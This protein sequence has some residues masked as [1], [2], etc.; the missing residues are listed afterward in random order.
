MSPRR[1][2]RSFVAAA[3]LSLALAISGFAEARVL[4]LRT[5]GRGD[6]STFQAGVDE[7]LGEP[8]EWERDTL[9]VHPGT[10]DEDVSLEA[11]RRF[12]A[13]ILCIGGPDQTEVRSLRGFSTPIDGLGHLSIRGL[14][15]RHHVGLGV[16]LPKPFSIPALVIEDCRF[17]GD[18]DIPRAYGGGSS[19]FI[20]CEFLGRLALGAAG[21]H[22]SRCRFTGKT[23]RLALFTDFFLN[24][25]QCVFSGA[26]TAV[27]T[28]TNQTDNVYFEQCRFNDVATGIAVTLDPNAFGPSNYWGVL[29]RNCVFED[30]T[31]SAILVTAV[32]PPQDLV[33]RITMDVSG[34]RFENCGRAI[35]GRQSA[36]LALRMAADTILASHDAG[37]EASIA[38]GSLEGVVIR[39]GGADGARLTLKDGLDFKVEDCHFVGNGGDGLGLIDGRGGSAFEVGLR[40]NSSLANGGAGIRLGPGSASDPTAILITHN[41]VAGNEGGGLLIQKAY[42]GRTE[43]NNAWL[44]QGDAFAGLKGEETNL[45]LDPQ[46]C[47]PSGSDVSVA[48][49][50]PCGPQGPYGQIGARGVGCNRMGVA[51]DALPRSHRWIN[52]QSKAGVGIA[53]LG[54]RLFD[55]RRVDAAS[56][57]ANGMAASPRPNGA[58]AT[59]VEDVN[60]D[61]QPDL[62]LSFESR[63]LPALSNELRLEGRTIDGAAFEGGDQVKFA[64]GKGTRPSP[65]L[66]PGSLALV[67]PSPQRAGEVEVSAIVAEGDAAK[68]EMF[69]VTGRR[70]LS[71]TLL[72]E[73]SAQRVRLQGA[74]D[75]RSGVYLVRMSQRGASVTRRVVLTN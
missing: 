8:S 57:L 13:A 41:L 51:V 30:I 64:P 22:V 28:V 67:V 61:G 75:L 32:G 6:V 38:G 63:T 18:V 53:I 40:R 65:A 14:R 56:V 66:D 36:P 48:S 31:G 71:R 2:P 3:F 21:Y 17:L 69:D 42:D 24:V 74:D 4:V 52:T 16:D 68:L 62:L 12:D 37:I 50:S 44:N 11:T 33:R 47:D 9:Q 45:E 27:V 20:G 5:D 1:L 43:S 60:R 70:I 39:Q 54:Q 29:V 35:D 26:D 46:L 55:S 34:S 23:A 7:L 59:H 58:H 72:P 25:E 19:G 49:L 15:V 73:G 10:Y